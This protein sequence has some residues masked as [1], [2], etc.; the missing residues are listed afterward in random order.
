M[1]HLAIR[2]LV[3]SWADGTVALRGV[4][5]EI[6][7][8]S[9][10]TLLGPSGCGKTTLLRVVAGLEPAGGGSVHLGTRDITRVPAGDRAVAIVLQG[11]PL[12]PHMTTREHV[13]FPLREGADG[14][15]GGER[16]IRELEALLGLDAIGTRRGQELSGGERQRVALGWALARGPGVVLLDEPLGAL[17]PVRRRA[18]RDELREWLRRCG[19]TVLH[20]THDQEEALA[21]ADRLAVMRDGAIVQE[22]GP[23]SVFARPADRFVA[24]FLGSPPTTFL[25]GTVTDDAAGLCVLA[26]AGTLRVP[27]PPDARAVLGGSRAVVLGVRPGSIRLGIDG[28]CPAVVERVA[29]LGAY[30]DVSLVLAGGARLLTRVGAPERPVAGARMRIGLRAE[31][32]LVFEPGLPGR[33]LYPAPEHG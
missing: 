2:G 19:A 4:S 32:V 20:V 23:E 29:F 6:P 16:W 28:G 17:D 9:Y 24:G 5:L 18:V 11:A 3:K 1:A 14:P 33:R 22:G 15:D 30:A 8:G 12:Y 7:E 31:A 13:R 27:L 21:L 26:A 10:S 25:E